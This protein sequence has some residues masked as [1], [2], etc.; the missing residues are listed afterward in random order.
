[1]RWEIRYSSA[2]MGYIEV[3]EDQVVFYLNY[4]GPYEESWTFDEFLAGEANSLWGPFGAEI[5]DEVTAEVR[6]RLTG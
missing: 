1:V 3:L 4:R 6:K 2:E 5:M